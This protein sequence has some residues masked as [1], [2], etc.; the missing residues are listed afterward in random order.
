M[1][2]LTYPQVTI[3]LQELVKRTWRFGYVKAYYKMIADHALNDSEFQQLSKL[4]FDRGY[5][6]RVHGQI[7]LTDD[8][9][10]KAKAHYAI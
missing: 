1:S 7:L 5:F 8:G 10:A 2:D 3:L 4:G 6:Q 9:I